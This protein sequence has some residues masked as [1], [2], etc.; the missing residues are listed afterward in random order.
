QPDKHRAVVAQMVKVKPE[1]VVQTGDLVGGDGSDPKDWQEAY[2]IIAPLRALGPYYMAMGNHDRGNPEIAKQL[3]LPADERMYYTVT[4]GNCLFIVLNTNTIRLSGK[5]EEQ[6]TWFQEQLQTATAEHRFVVLHHPLYTI[7]AYRPGDPT[8]RKRLLPILKQYPVTAAF[9]AH[10]HGYYRT[11]REGNTF[12]V[13]AG[14]GAPLYDQH[15][16]LA[17]PGDKFKKTYHFIEVTVTGPEVAMKVIDEQGLEVDSFTLPERSQ[18]ATSAAPAA[19]G[20]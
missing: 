9:S 20:S 18:P 15:P 7:G 13:T 19:A 10:D 12:I 16:E 6:V 17:L 4:R 11:S 3:D 1:F 2:E 8:V 5:D 14:G